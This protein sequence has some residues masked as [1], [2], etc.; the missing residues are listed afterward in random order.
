LAYYAAD[1]VDRLASGEDVERFFRDT[2]NGYLVTRDAQLDKL[3]GHLPS[4]VSVLSRQR[5]FLRSGEVV[6]IGRPARNV[7]LPNPKQTGA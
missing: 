4:D 2:P 5:R 3:A 7:R 1:R 6:L